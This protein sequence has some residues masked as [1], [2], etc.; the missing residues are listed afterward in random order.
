M[1]N[2]SPNFAL[3]K[4]PVVHPGLVLCVIGKVPFFRLD[5]THMKFYQL[6]R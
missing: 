1:V 3:L 4:F 2:S 5:E 6:A